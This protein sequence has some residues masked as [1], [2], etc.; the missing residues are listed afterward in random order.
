[1]QPDREKCS[2]QTS[3]CPFSKVRYQ[4]TYKTSEGIST[5]AYLVQF[6]IILYAWSSCK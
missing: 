5:A 6:I 1:M 2:F 3:F 4:V